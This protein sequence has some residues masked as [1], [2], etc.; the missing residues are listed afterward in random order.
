MVRL[1][2]HASQSELAPLEV[3][4]PAADAV[5]GIFAKSDHEFWFGECLPTSILWVQSGEGRDPG[6]ITQAVGAPLAM[7][8]FE[9]EKLPATLAPE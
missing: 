8:V 7:G 2:R 3:S 9:I 5:I 4:Q 1:N 6:Q